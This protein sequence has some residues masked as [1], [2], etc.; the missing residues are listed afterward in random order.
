[1]TNE[2]N[3]AT[4]REYCAHARASRVG[5]YATLGALCATLLLLQAFGLWNDSYAYNEHGRLAA[6][7]IKIT[8]ADFS[9][10]RVNPPCL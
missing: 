8:R 9:P 2:R 1:M 3:L 4:A 5:V 10:F 7:L 6:G